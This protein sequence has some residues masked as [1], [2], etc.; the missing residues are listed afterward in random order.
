M[1][2]IDMPAHKSIVV[3]ITHLVTCVHV[4]TMEATFKFGTESLLIHTIIAGVLHLSDNIAISID[5]CYIG[6]MQCS[7]TH[8]LV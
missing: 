1:Y 2:P 4:P 6:K 3:V 7:F 5:A 8:F